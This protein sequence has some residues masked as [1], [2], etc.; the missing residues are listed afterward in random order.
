MKKNELKK[1]ILELE[2]LNFAWRRGICWNQTILK[3][4]GWTPTIVYCIMFGYSAFSIFIICSW[5]CVYF[6]GWYVF[7]KTF[8]IIPPLQFFQFILRMSVRSARK[9]F[10]LSNWCPINI[11]LSLIFK[12]NWVFATKSD[13]W[14]KLNSFIS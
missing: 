9:K 11:F 6:T 3:H 8:P 2:L 7:L 4:R 13:L 10:F 12:R 14:Q 1:K 5:G